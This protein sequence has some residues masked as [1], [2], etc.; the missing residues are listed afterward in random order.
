MRRSAAPIRILSGE[1]MIAK[2]AITALVGLVVLMAATLAPAAA[3]PVQGKEYQLIDPPQPPLDAGSNGKRVE[4]IEF[5]YYGCPHCYN[6]QPALKVWLKNAPK[7]I[8]FRRMP[9]V[10]QKSWIPLT[11]AYYAL[12]AVGAVEKLHDDVF[13]A[14][15]KQGIHFTDKNILVEWAAKR[16]VDAKK[17]GE[18]YDSFAV[19]TKTQRSVQ[20][21][22]AY[23]I[24]GTP[25]VV[26]AGRYITAPS[27]TMNADNSVNYQRFNEVLTGLVEMARAT[28]SAK[29]G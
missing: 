23:G 25:S 1:A 14:V 4:V 19:Q 13:D 9:T 7:D 11:R 8:E 29:K 22:R 21:T 24:T 18:A 28:A 15:H 12:E 10:F 3:P 17:L 5:F 16:G 6:L 20:L 26:V 27:L 2:R